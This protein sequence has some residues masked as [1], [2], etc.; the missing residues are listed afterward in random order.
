[1]GPAPDTTLLL[2]G[3]RAGAPI[4][5][6]PGEVLAK[7]EWIALTNADMT[8][9]AGPWGISFAANLTPDNF[10][11]S[12]G[13]TEDMFIG[14]MRNGKHLGAGRPILPPMRGRAL[15]S[16]RM[17]SSRPCSLISSR[18]SRFKTKCPSPFRCQLPREVWRLP[19]KRFRML[20]DVCHDTRA[21]QWRTL[22][23][24]PALRRGAVDT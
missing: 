19:S 6:F 22:V 5:A 7:G 12:G 14:A 20:V 16:A 18:S 11:G 24:P 3:H 8:A 1:M 15:P 2:S 10:T 17:M 21:R 13:W 23:C 4:P 9:W